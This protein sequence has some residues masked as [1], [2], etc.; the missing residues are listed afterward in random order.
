MSD[1]QDPAL[2]KCIFKEFKPRKNATIVAIR[3][4]GKIESFVFAYC[5]RKP[6][7]VT[8]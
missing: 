1:D 2:K 6:R 8:E 5:F 7:D 4:K 3:V